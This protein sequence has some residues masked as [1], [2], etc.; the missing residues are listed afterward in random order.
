MNCLRHESELTDLVLVGCA[1]RVVG[2]SF[3]PLGHGR[4]VQPGMNKATAVTMCC[5]EGW[6]CGSVVGREF[7]SRCS[8]GRSLRLSFSHL[9][10]GVPAAVRVGRDEVPLHAPTFS[11]SMSISV[12]HC[13]FPGTPCAGDCP[14]IQTNGRLLAVSP[15]MTEFLAVVNTASHQSELCTLPPCLPYGRG[16]S[17]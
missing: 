13:P 15:D 3:L 16:L 4:P 8:L 10:L 1:S 7:S 11:C 9:I 14:R 2:H 12:L 6:S 17:I 5:C